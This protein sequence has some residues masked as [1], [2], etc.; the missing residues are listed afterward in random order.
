MSRHECI[1]MF[2]LIMRAL[3]SLMFHEDSQR[4]ADIF[5]DYREFMDNLIFQQEKD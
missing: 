1:R 4:R 3:F 5:N 2:E